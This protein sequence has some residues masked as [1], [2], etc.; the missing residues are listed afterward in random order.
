MLVLAGGQTPD[1]GV[2]PVV[3]RRLDAG[4][5]VAMLQNPTCPVLCV[6]GG[7]PHKPPVV[8]ESGN[9]VIHESWSCA[10]YLIAK[11][12]SSTNILK[13]TSSFDT[14]G[15]CYFSLFSHAVPA[16]WRR[17]AVVTSHFHMPRSQALYEDMFKLAAHELFDD[18]NRFSLWF[19]SV[20]DEG[21]FPPEVLQSRRQREA[22]SLLTWRG[23]SA[24]I[25]SIKKLHSWLFDTHLCYSVSRQGEWDVAAKA[26]DDKALAS[27]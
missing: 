17:I 9:Y 11:G 14:V 1:G 12:L 7:S 19:V 3:E 13:E 21:L 5:Q 27:Y 6:G 2:P 8:S 23:N 16:G 10:E 24:K 25:T 22:A 4:L 18:P 15:N 26:V 20:S